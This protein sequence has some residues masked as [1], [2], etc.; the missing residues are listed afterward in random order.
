MPRTQVVQILPCTAWHDPTRVGELSLEYNLDGDLLHR[1]DFINTG[2]AAPESNIS[3][4]PQANFPFFTVPA[5]VTLGTHTLTVIVVECAGNQTFVFD[6]ATYTYPLLD[7]GAGP[8]LPPS[9]TPVHAGKSRVGAIVGGVVGG[10]VLLLL[11]GLLLDCVRR[12]KR[13]VRMRFG[14]LFGFFRGCYINKSDF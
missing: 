13:Q 7:A 14:E 9:A 10:V 1:I 8:V 3:T 5:S 6:Y 11:V 4:V 12:R 2:S